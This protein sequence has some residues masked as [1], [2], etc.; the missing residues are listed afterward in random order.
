MRL[1]ESDDWTSLIPLYGQGLTEAGILRINESIRTYVYCILG[2][3]VMLNQDILN[4][5]VQRQFNTL[6]EDAING[7]RLVDSIRTFES[8]LNKTGMKL[9]Y[10]IGPNLQTLPSDM[11]LKF[12][13]SL[14]ADDESTIEKRPTE[15]TN[16][17]PMTGVLLLAITLLELFF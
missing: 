7:I 2:S 17:M 12:G 1:Q 8:T 4:L 16:H 14:V 5:D 3:Q 11:K 15:T 6:V 10:T 9:D 13:T